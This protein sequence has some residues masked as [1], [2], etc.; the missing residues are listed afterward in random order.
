MHMPHAV[1]AHELVKHYSNRNGAVEAVRGVDLHVAAGEV[2]GFLGPNGAGK[3]TTVKMLTMLLTIT[4][5]HYASPAANLNAVLNEDDNVS[6][7]GEP[8]GSAKNE[9]ND[10]AATP[11]PS[12]DSPSGEKSNPALSRDEMCGLLAELERL[13]NVRVIDAIL[14]GYFELAESP[15]GER[16]NGFHGDAR[17][18]DARLAELD[19]GSQL[20]VPAPCQDDGPSTLEPEIPQPHGCRA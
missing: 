6:A 10:A 15:C 20:D 14:L 12:S 18:G 7:P 17:A 11:P 2:F 3:S 4:S 19:V 9:P 8:A 5:P 1:E 16:A 13:T